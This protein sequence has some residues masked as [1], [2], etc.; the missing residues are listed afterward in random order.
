MDQL[1]PRH[2]TKNLKVRHD[3]SP[4]VLS[5]LAMLFLDGGHSRKAP[6]NDWLS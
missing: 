3:F 5:I 4:P 2:G 6:V 1:V